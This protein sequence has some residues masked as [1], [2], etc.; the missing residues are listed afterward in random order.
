MGDG[1]QPGA[2]DPDWASA[3]VTLT[4]TSRR[5]ERAKLRLLNGAHSTLAYVGLLRG[6]ATVGEAMEDGRISSPSCAGCCCDEVLPTLRPV[7]GLES[8]AT[9][10]RC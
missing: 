7:R 9:W 5:Y 3:G 2:G 10:R 8:R 1:G 4:P 6:Y